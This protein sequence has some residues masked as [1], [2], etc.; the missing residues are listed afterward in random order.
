MATIGNSTVTLPTFIPLS[1]AARK[2]KLNENV[3]TRL[4]GDGRIEAAQIPTGDI[5]VSD[6]DLD[7]TQIKERIIEEKFGHLRGRTIGVAEAAREY[8]ISIPTIARWVKLGYIGKLGQDG[9]KYLLDLADVAYC[10]D[11][12]RQQGGSQ[13]KRIFDREGYPYQVKNT[14]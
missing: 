6:D 3:L 5:L 12:Y 13:G 11:V 8:G 1:E 7:H 4:I 10:A 2:Y 9:Q 14:A